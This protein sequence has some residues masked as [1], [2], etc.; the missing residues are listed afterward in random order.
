VE[1]VVADIFAWRPAG[2]FDFVLFAFWM[3]HVPPSRFEGF[4]A[5]VHRALRPGGRVFFVD[6][7]AEQGATARDQEPL[8]DSGLARRRLNDGREFDIVKVYYEP[9]SLEC[10]LQALGWTGWIRASGRHFLYGTMA[11]IA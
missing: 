2:A 7:L 5:L 9:A 10:R 11:P 3:S 8:D 1:Y 6:S 4:W